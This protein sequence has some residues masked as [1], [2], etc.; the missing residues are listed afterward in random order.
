MKISHA[1]L[2]YKKLRPPKKSP[3][4]SRYR[5][6]FFSQLDEEE[7]ARRRRRIPRCSLLPVKWSPWRRVYQSR[8]DQAMITF[9]GFDCDTFAYVLSKF[10]PIFSEYSPF[11]DTKY[12]YIVRRTNRRGRKRS[13]AAHDALGLVLGWTRTRGSLMAL[14]MLFGLTMSPLQKYLQFS[15]RILIKVLANNEL[16]QIRM[17]CLDDIEKYRSMI[18]RR[19]P[20][21]PDVWGTMDGLKCRI[22]QPSDCLVQRRFYN[23]WKCDHFVTAVLCFAPDGTIPAAFYNVPGCVHDSQVATWGGI[24]AKLKA[25]YEKTGLKY[26]V[27]SAFSGT[28]LPFLIKSGQDKYTTDPSCRTYEERVANIAKKKDATSMRQAAEWGMRAVESSFPRLKD[29]MIYEEHGER[30]ITMNDSSHL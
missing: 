27:D 17:P 3:V 26:V 7:K 10:G 29:T 5:K 8:N 20:N 12:G 22:E 18:A 21:L 28:T 9:T 16:A 13:I 30:Q 14:Q 25:I 4:H 24:Y 6:T 23:G 15:K 1:L 2:L 19:H 11:I